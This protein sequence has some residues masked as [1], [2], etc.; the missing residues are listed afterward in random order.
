MKNLSLLFS[1]ILFFILLEMPQ[2]L[3]TTHTWLGGNAAWDD[4]NQWDTGTI[5]NETD[6]VIIPSGT[7]RIFPGDTGLANS[8]HVHQG[9][10]LRLY[11]GGILK[12]TDAVN[13]DAFFNEGRAYIYG[14][15][16][17]TNVSRTSNLNTARGIYNVDFFYCSSNA[18][19][20][21]ENIDNDAINNYTNGYFYNNGGTF[22]IYGLSN[23]G[24]Y[25]RAF[26]GNTGTI[27]I[28]AN[29]S[30]PN[31]G[32]VNHGDF[33]N[34]PAGVIDIQGGG[35]AG[36]GNYS[37]SSVSN[38][39]YNDGALSINNSN[40]MGLENGGV[41]VNHRN[42]V[43]TTENSSSSGFYNQGSGEVDNLGFIGS[44]NSGVFGLFNLGEINN[45]GSID[46][47]F[48]QN[49]GYYGYLGSDF[50]NDATL[51]ISSTASSDINLDGSL[52]NTTEAVMSI[53]KRISIGSGD[54][55]NNGMLLCFLNSGNHWI[56]SAG[57]MTNNGVVEDV[58][59]RLLSS[60][61]HNKQLRVRPITGSMQVGVPY[62]NALDVTSLSN[63]TIL[64][65]Y[66]SNNINSALAGTYNSNTNEFTP[67]S[68][69]I[70]LSDLYVYVQINASNRRLLLRVIVNGTISPLTNNQ[71]MLQLTQQEN[72]GK[73][74][75]SSAD[76]Q[77]QVF[78][79]PTSG[80]V[81]V[82]SSSFL[83]KPASLKLINALGQVIY[84][85]QI[86]AGDQQVNLDLPNTLKDG[87]YYLS[88]S[89][90]GKAIDVQ[91]IQLL[92]Q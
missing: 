20:L 68:N 37:I 33:R 84:Q 24:I 44:S 49:I 13:T 39:L 7:A 59:N 3:A 92:R 82:E 6:E 45:D 69:A 12:I 28:D 79:N 91:R 42:G 78:P 9:A 35:A 56:G 50:I 53:N 89:Q 30:Y 87:I 32:I 17:I 47:S 54:F 26:F 77:V 34:Y 83:A 70:G 10:N 16:Y 81:Q 51:N 61:F 23:D 4:P 40:R 64:D 65:W 31:K 1:F 2:G 5:P 48:S 86:P 21:L 14:E 73:G 67:N 46:I 90:E 85:Q 8:L 75:A 74:T 80:M 18:Y 43:L 27:N 55:V 38:S 52:T 71:D 88:I 58:H 63:V 25:N 57:S 62:P 19:V 11:T 72:Q 60:N 15:L 66:T 29:N 36:F 41:F 76:I 22:D